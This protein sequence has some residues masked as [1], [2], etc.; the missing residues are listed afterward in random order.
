MIDQMFTLE[1]IRA[2][3]RAA[4]LFDERDAFLS[5]LFDQG[6]RINQLKCTA[7]TLLHII[8][9]MDL[10]SLRSIQPSEVRDAAARWCEDAYRGRGK[11]PKSPKRFFTVAMQW[12]RFANVISPVI[13]VKRE[14]EAILENFD[15]HITVDRGYS[16]YSVRSYSRR[17]ADFLLW[18]RSRTS[19]F[20]EIG[21]QD[22][23]DYLKYCRERNFRPK[24]I[25]GIVTA[26]RALFRYAASQ[27]LTSHRIAPRIKYIPVCRY[28][29]KPRGPEWRDVRRLLDYGFGA[30]P[31]EL[32][33]AA[34]VSLCAI[35]AF[36]KSE[37]ER[38]MLD[39]IDWV[40]EI[41]TIRRGKSGKVQRFPLQFEVGE[42]ILRYLREGRAKCSR[43]NLFITMNPPYRPMDS[44]VIW[45]IL[46][47]RMKNLKIH[48][49]NFGCHALRHS[50]ATKL[51]REGSPL[52]DVADFLGHSD[53]SSVSIYAKFDLKLLG[54]VADFSLSG[55]L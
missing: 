22:V 3:Q 15:H 32:R 8:R 38:L 35:Y 20:S 41:I 44:N 54:R 42:K 21:L 26:L 47:E 40:N 37:A 1:S 43:K 6:I 30:K 18:A 12:F 25:N 29:T 24:T 11:R 36:R 52:K 23:E 49:E 4:P 7:S 53:M 27:S 13:T 5:H 39:D 14:S 45:S 10:S 2:R 16:Y 51:L 50:C 19:A 17:A 48:S 33:A 28:E 9:L 46:A 31:S 34:F 55:L